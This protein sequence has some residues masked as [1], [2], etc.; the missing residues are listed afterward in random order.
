MAP[1]PAGPAPGHGGAAVVALTVG[2]LA[3]LAGTATAWLVCA[4]PS[5]ERDPDAGFWNGFIGCSTVAT[6]LLVAAAHNRWTAAACA[7]AVATG[8]LAA[9]RLAVRGR[10][11][12]ALAAARSLAA[13]RHAAL[14]ARHDSVLLAW[15]RYA[16]DPAAALDFPAMNDVGVPEVSALARAL[17]EAESLRR[18]HHA[19][20]TVAHAA[21]GPG[22]EPAADHY[23]RAVVRLE[24]AFRLAEQA[25]TGPGTPVSSRA[26]GAP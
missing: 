22:S 4:G 21:A 24:S 26:A 17:A 9:G 6:L 14:A 16:L 13:A 7:A 23:R 12:R 19:P 18:D 2:V 10:R 1:Q 20:E 11:R 5:R 3:V 25:A 15:G 8:G